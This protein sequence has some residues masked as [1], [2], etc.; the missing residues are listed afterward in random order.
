MYYFVCKSFQDSWIAQLGSLRYFEEYALLPLQY[1]KYRQVIQE[2]K[3]PD[4][5]AE[6]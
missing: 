1:S 5:F 6:S 2:K 4:N 3:I